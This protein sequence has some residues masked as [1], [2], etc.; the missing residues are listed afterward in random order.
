MLTIKKAS[1]TEVQRAR[2]FYETRLEREV[3]LTGPF[4]CIREIFSHSKNNKNF[5]KSFKLGK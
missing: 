4:G 1:V 2:P 3:G 5:F